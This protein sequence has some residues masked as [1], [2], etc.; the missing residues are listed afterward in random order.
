MIEYELSDI[1]AY[2]LLLQFKQHN[3]D[4]F[5]TNYEDIPDAYKN[6]FLNY[7]NQLKDI[8]VKLQTKE[9]DHVGIKFYEGVI[10][11]IYYVMDHPGYIPGTHLKK[12]NFDYLIERSK[13][14][15]PGILA[16]SEQEYINGYQATAAF[17]LGK[18]KINKELIK[19]FKFFNNSF[20]IHQS[21]TLN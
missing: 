21:S 14:E 5:K 18:Y 6:N 15:L 7:L 9:Q 16:R 1:R 4:L 3:L 10:K 19:I 13:S 17:F 11:T 2:P 12:F 20:H 8:Y